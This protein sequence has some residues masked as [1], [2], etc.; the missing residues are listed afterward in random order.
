NSEV[1]LFS[2]EGSARETWCEKR[3]MHPL[4]LKKPRLV[5]GFLFLTVKKI[6]SAF[7]LIKNKTSLEIIQGNAHKAF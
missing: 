6:S 7:K 1:K 4:N 3:S 5:W 2:A